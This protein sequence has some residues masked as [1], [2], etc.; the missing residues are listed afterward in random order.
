MSQY[1]S[2][3]NLEGGSFDILYGTIGTPDQPLIST[4]GGLTSIR[5]TNIPNTSWPFVSLLNQNVSSTSSPAFDNVTANSFNGRVIGVA[6]EAKIVVNANQPNITSLLNLDS[7]QNT[8]I[9]AGHWLLVADLDQKVSSGSSPHFVNVTA[10]LTGDVTGNCSGT[11]NTVTNSTQGSITS[12]PNLSQ[13]RNYNIQLIN[14]SNLALLNQNVGLAANPIFTNVAASLYRGN[15]EGDVE[16]NVEGNL[17]GNVTGN[18]TGNCSGSATTVTAPQ[19]SAITSLPNLAYVNGHPIL[20]VNWQYLAAMDQYV[21]TG[22]TVQFNFLQCNTLQSSYS[23]SYQVVATHDFEAPYLNITGSAT[24]RALKGT[25]NTQNPNDTLVIGDN[26]TNFFI[27]REGTAQQTI[28]NYNTPCGSGETTPFQIYDGP[29]ALGQRNLAFAVTSRGDNSGLTSVV[30]GQ[31]LTVGQTTRGPVD[32]CKLYVTTEGVGQTAAL[33]LSKDYFARCDISVGRTAADARV[34]VVGNTGDYFANTQN[35]D[36]ILRNDTYYNYLHLGAGSGYSTIKVGFNRLYF[37]N[38]R[39]MNSANCQ[40]D[41]STGEITHPSSSRRYKENIET[42][43]VDTSAIFKL[44]AKE[45]DYKQENGGGHDIGFIAE[46]VAEHKDLRYLLC[47]DKEEKPCSVKYDKLVVYLLEELKKQNKRIE[48]L[49]NQLS[50]K[51]K[52]SE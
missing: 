45:F 7:I 30:V 5:G 24:I 20:P 25:L 35:G 50:N 47:F 14:W 27:D 29:T 11:A 39:A 52:F 8:H 44:E 18:V 16:G 28:W 17:T 10:N 51:R 41:A 13:V 34:G 12:L 49:E 48:L 42:C 46:E 32:T 36:V 6:D 9:P 40:M 4:L 33:F 19:Q 15:L 1:Q 22:A 43:K 26:N 37:Y 2:N 31:A 21:N 23:T 3:W 38:L